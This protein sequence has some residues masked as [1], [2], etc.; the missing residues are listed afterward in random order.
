MKK[1]LIIM[2]A[3]FCGLIVLV[4]IG[5]VVLATRGTRLD[6]ESRAYAQTAIPSILR[7]WNEEAFFEMASPEMKR[8][9]SAKQ[10]DGFFQT[11]RRLGNLQHCDPVNGQATIHFVPGQLGTPTAHYETAAKF[12]QGDG[13]IILDLI[14]HGD[15]WQL[16]GFYINSPNFVQK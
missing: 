7:T 11:F 13:R 4:V 12:E 2:G 3:I 15:Q 16:L 8:A 5:I 10:A 14:K 9:V 6:K 1:F